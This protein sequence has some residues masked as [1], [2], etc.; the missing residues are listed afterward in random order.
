MKKV[1]T[2][3]LLVVFLAGMHVVA[4][5]RETVRQNRTQETS[6]FAGSLNSLALQRH[7]RRW[8]VRRAYRNN[9]QRWNRR[10]RRNWNRRH[11]NRVHRNR[12]RRMRRM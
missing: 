2:T 7:R 4:D 9:R 10:Y 11:W 1:L 8:R 12:I 5:G 3:L 6:A